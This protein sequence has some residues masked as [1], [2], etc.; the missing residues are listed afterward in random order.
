M[1]YI[2]NTKLWNN[3]SALGF[4]T[5]CGSIIVGILGTILVVGTY[6]GIP[7]TLLTS[8]IALFIAIGVFF[9]K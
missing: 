2:V 1:K 9:V 3:L 6:I 7:L 4:L 5:L 8:A